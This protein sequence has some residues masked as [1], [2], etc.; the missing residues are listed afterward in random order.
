MQ[1][2]LMGA[3]EQEAV[4]SDWEAQESAKPAENSKERIQL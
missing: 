2:C 4:G 3:K 1:Q